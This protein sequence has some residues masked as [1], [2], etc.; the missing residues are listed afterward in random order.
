MFNFNTKIIDFIKNENLQPILNITPFW[1]LNTNIKKGNILFDYTSDEL[2]NLYQLQNDMHYFIK[3]IENIKCFY[4]NDLD[5]IST[6]QLRNYQKE[7]L[8]NFNNNRFLSILSSRQMGITT[9]IPIYLIKYILSNKNKNI[10][11]L[12][13]KNHSSIEILN[14]FKDIYYYLPFYLKP[15][16]LT[17]NKGSISFDNGCMIKC[18]N[19]KNNIAIGY[20]V[21]IMIMLEPLHLKDNKLFKIFNSI[22]PVMS[23]LKDT[24]LFL[25]NSGLGK[26]NNDFYKNYFT[27]EIDNVFKKYKYHY[28]LISNRDEEWKNRMINNFGI[29]L[30]YNEFELKK[31]KS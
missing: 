24:K 5:K 1:K 9:L 17:W 19:I 6:I 30:F 28:L 22:L 2:K 27:D 26:Y 14:K 4:N 15:G 29:E 13:D 3:F 20:N 25:I 31:Y 23:V 21:D 7:I 18:D 8:Q 12:S 10:I 11:I 16:V